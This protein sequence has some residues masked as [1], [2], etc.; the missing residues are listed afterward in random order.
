ME[1]E[2]SI[3]EIFD[4]ISILEIKVNN[5]KR[6]QY[7]NARR[8]LDYLKRKIKE[9][10]DI[11]YV[12]ISKLYIINKELWAIEDAI[13]N[14]EFL[15]EFDEE[16]IQLARSVYITN[17]KRGKIKKEINLKYKSMFIEEKSYNKYTND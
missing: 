16:F 10:P 8:E 5:L 14:K 7:T 3:G 4:K 9:M 17:D 6:D 15:Q 13:R 11:E 1:I 12:D 2:V